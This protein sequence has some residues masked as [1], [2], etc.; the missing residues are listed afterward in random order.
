[1]DSVGTQ[2]I[3]DFCY[4]NNEDGSID[5][6][7]SV[8]DKYKISRVYFNTLFAAKIPVNQEKSPCPDFTFKSN[9]TLFREATEVIGEPTKDQAGTTTGGTTAETT[10]FEEQPVK[11]ETTTN[12]P[13]TNDPTATETAVNEP[14][15]DEPINEDPTK[16]TS[17]D[18][19]IDPSKDEPTGTEP[20]PK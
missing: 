11:T 18:P 13:A 8:F 12:D 3:P 5:I 15:K 16:D 2:K 20:T 14:V 10:A 6:N 1:L 17:I 4:V 19:N 9:F 7:Y